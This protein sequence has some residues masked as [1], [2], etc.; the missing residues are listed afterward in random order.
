MAINFEF[1]ISIFVILS[2]LSTVVTEVI[3]K[4]LDNCGKTWNPNLIAFVVAIVAGGIGTTG[5]L[6]YKGVPFDATAVIT[7]IAMIVA[8][9]SGSCLGYD[10]IKELIQGFK[11]PTTINEDNT[12]E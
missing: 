12:C 9:Y 3:K 4:S 7:V 10:K 2:A 11:N 8:V 6:I 5:I 1:I